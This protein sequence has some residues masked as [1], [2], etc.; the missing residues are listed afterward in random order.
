MGRVPAQYAFCPVRFVPNAKLTRLDKL[1]V[2]FDAL[3]LSRLTGG[4]PLIAKILHGPDYTTTAVRLP[5]LMDEAQLRIAEL[6]AQQARDAPPSVILNKHCPAC[7]F[8][9]RC[10]QAA[11]EQEDLSLIRTISAK[12]RAKLNAKGIF[13]VT[14]LSYTYR[15]RRRPVRHSGLTLRHEPALKALAI[16]KQRVHVVGT[17]CFTIPE[18]AVYLDVEGIPD[19]NFYYLVGLRYQR[20]GRDV[21]EAFWA[22]DPQDEREM[23]AACLR[24]LTLLGDP[25]PVHFGSYET[26]FLKRMRTRYHEGSGQADFVSQLITSSVNVL[27]PLHAQVYFPTYSNSLKDIARHLGFRW[28]AA[29]ASGLHALMW[30]FGWET[31]RDPSL[32]QGLLTYNAEDCEATQRVAEAIA[33]ICSEQATTVSQT[34]SV[35]VNSMERD[36]PYQFG[37]LTY[38]I[39]EFKLIN[40]AAYWNYQRS[41]VYIRTSKFLRRVHKKAKAASQKVLKPNTLIKYGNNRPEFCQRCGS[42]RIN[43]NGWR[44]H[45]IYDLRFSATGVKRWIVQEDFIRYQCW[46]CKIGYNERPRQDLYGRDLKA[47]VLYQ[48]IE[49]RVSQCAIARNMA[50]LFGYRMGRNSINRIKESS[51]KQYVA[52]YEAILANIS[53]GKLVH[54]DETKVTLT[55]I[56]HTGVGEEH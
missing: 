56:S 14:Q 26:E 18:N 41:K 10:R 39:P 1:A 43:K 2:A 35:N 34:R 13:T 52:T 22:D 15:P 16:R 28:S 29:N 51:S 36:N 50:A 6:T 30:R 19:Q 37:A 24:A 48:M 3:A 8:Q 25:V 23:W 27:G 46:T 4:P 45:I 17:P 7:E 20:A 40:E 47:Y 42:R 32:K 31:S 33:T 54:A 49:M 21:H 12:E 5:K 9:S 53:T 55:R 38:A 44:K 11:T